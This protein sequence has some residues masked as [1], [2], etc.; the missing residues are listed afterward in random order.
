MRTIRISDEV[1]NEI[2]KRGKFGETPNDVLER[3]FNLPTNS[4]KRTAPR[5]RIASKRMTVKVQGQE[6]TLSFSDGL[7]KRWLLPNRNDQKANREIREEIF[8]FAKQNGATDGQV[9]AI[10]K[11][12]NNAGYYLTGPRSSK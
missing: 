7:S 5:K 8:N 10:T 11:E 3:E 4:R 12:L 1:W 9:A 6:L 2:A